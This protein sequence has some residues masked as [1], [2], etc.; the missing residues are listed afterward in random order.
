MAGG[1]SEQHMYCTDLSL[2]L[3][4][5]RVNLN[6]TEDI[7]LVRI[8]SLHG[9]VCTCNIPLGVGGRGGLGGG[10]KS[11]RHMYC[12]DLS[13]VLVVGRVNLNRTEDIAL[14]R[15]VSLNVR[16]KYM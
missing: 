3:V 1:E 5:G 15:L 6:R 16:G 12:T 7:A 4:G 9:R 2:V 13:L 8:V 14:M 11:E 10:G